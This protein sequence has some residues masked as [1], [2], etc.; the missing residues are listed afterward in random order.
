MYLE[1]EQYP[2]S[3]TSPTPNSQKASTYQ[4]NLPVEIEG[5]TEEERL[6]ITRQIDE[7]A[8]RSTMG[9][10]GRFTPEKKGAFFPLVVNILA[11]VA[12]GAGI[13]LSNY[14]FNQRVEE[15]NTVKN[16]IQSAE[17]K[18]LEEVKKESEKKLQAKEAE[19]SKIREDLDQIE[20]ERQNLQENMEQQIALKEE[21][22]QQQLDEALAAEKARLESQGISQAELENRLDSF[23]SEQQQQYQSALAE[24]R[25]ESVRQLEEKQKELEEAKAT[26][27]QILNEAH[28]ERQQLLQAAQE[29]EEELR[30]QFQ[31]ETERLTQASS[32]AKQELSQL[33]EVRK[34]EQLY[35]DRIDG[36]YLDI[37]SAIEDGNPGAAREK[38]EEL[39]A[40]IQSPAVSRI[41][42]FAKRREV[43]SFLL[44][45]LEEQAAGS[46]GGGESE[47]LLESAKTISTLT[48][49]V[50]EAKALEEEGNLYDARR[51]YNRALELIPA[52]QTAVSGLENINEGEEASRIREIIGEA[53]NA[54]EENR[55]DEALMLYGNAAIE[56]ASEHRELSR[57][58][59][60]GIIALN[61]SKIEELTKN[62]EKQNAEYE[63]QIA[64]L[65]ERRDALQE[66]LKTREEELV[67][68]IAAQKS[69]QEKQLTAAN[70][71]LQNLRESY[72]N[73]LAENS[74]EKATLNEKVTQQDQEIDTLQKKITEKEGQ[75]S[76]LTEDL[77]RLEQEQIK[78]SRRYQEA[79]GEITELNSDLEGAVNQ[80]A[81]LVTQG[82]SNSRLRSAVGRYEDFVQKSN[83]LLSSSDG[84]GS[85]A[86]RKEFEQ[87]LDSREVK[88]IFP[89]LSALYKK[90]EEN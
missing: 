85:E 64:D 34:N 74:E 29:R 33:E 82:E 46:A 52:V 58:A 44:D 4:G 41:A 32:E 42:S 73:L 75:I 77:D 68:Q 81:E 38:I 25:Q 6:E 17:G 7:A 24:Y 35:R 19:I 55:P 2:V 84:T 66:E 36:L 47:S 20:Q 3:S 14:Y 48:S 63:Q 23:Q 78:L 12:I 50:T 88:E 45:M 90:I 10:V 28:R 86:G 9:S 49:T 21:E 26:A 67:T 18:I 43:D 56:A 83:T 53:Q 39:R 57:T 13:Y 51:F 89:Q 22:L 16:D 40:L 11:I 79:Q 5:F 62:F 87:F 60:E 65:R 70:E 8:K 76:N 37:E 54:R 31:Q 61:N 15:L 27:E 72:D 59:T 71:E 30:L 80:I 1:K 69:E